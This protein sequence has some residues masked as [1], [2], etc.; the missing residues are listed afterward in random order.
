MEILGKYKR[1]SDIKSA[2]DYE[3]KNPH[4]D[5]GPGQRHAMEVDYHLFRKELKAELKKAGIDIGKS[6]AG[7]VH[8]YK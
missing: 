3:V 8:L 2:I 5:F 7:K 6:L 1:P 4:F